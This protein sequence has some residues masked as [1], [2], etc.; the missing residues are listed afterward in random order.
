M[1]PIFYRQWPPREVMW[2]WDFRLGSPKKLNVHQKIHV[3]GIW[4]KVITF[5]SIDVCYTAWY[6]IH[7][8]SKAELYK[9]AIY[10]KEGRRFRN[11]GSLDLK[12]PIEATRQEATTLILSLYTIKYCTVLEKLYF[13]ALVLRS[14]GKINIVLLNNKSL[15][16]SH[17]DDC[18]WIEWYQVRP[19]CY[20]FIF[21]GFKPHKCVICK[22]I[23]WYSEIVCTLFK[24]VLWD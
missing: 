19:L 11:N 10:A 4:R 23:A 6:I 1:D 8:V 3:D 15:V 14:I 22:P 16:S 12:K 7:G 2:V 13:F 21:N 17:M 20:R 5:E 9:Q 18:S 24:I